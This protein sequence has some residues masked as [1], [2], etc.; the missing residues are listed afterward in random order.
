MT[1][2][3]VRIDNVGQII[4]RLIYFRRCSKIDGKMKET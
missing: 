1:V 4:E 2:Q 3:K